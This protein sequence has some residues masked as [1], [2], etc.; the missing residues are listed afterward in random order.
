MFSRRIPSVIEMH[1]ALSEVI[2]HILC[3]NITTE[4]K[5]TQEMRMFNHLFGSLMDDFKIVLKE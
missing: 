5:K 1:A 3:D 2:D 4:K